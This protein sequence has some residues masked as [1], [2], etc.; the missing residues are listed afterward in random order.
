MAV[1]R[2]D[3]GDVDLLADAEFEQEF[4]RDP[5]EAAGSERWGHEAV[6]ETDED[7]RT[8]ALA[9]LAAGVG[10]QRFGGPGARRLDE[11]RAR[12][13]RTTST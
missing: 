13:R 2:S 11:T 1:T 4:S 9:Q 12:S 7:V 3:I 8:R 5:G 10:E 6:A